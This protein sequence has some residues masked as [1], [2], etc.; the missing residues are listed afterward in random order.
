MGLKAKSKQIIILIIIR[1]HL[2]ELIYSLFEFEC[3][4][5]SLSIAYLSLFSHITTFDKNCKCLE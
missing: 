4:W 3:V 2:G 5:E 1:V